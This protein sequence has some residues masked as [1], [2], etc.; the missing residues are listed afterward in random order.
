MEHEGRRLCTKAVLLF[1]KC[2]FYKMSVE[3]HISSKCLKFFLYALLCAAKIQQQYLIKRL[4]PLWWDEIE[5][6]LLMFNPLC[7]LQVSAR[8]SGT[9]LQSGRRFFFVLSSLTVCFLPVVHRCALSRW[10]LSA[11]PSVHA[12]FNPRYDCWTSALTPQRRLEPS[13][14]RAT[15]SLFPSPPLCGLPGKAF[16][17]C[18]SKICILTTSKSLFIG[19]RWVQTQRNR[20][21]LQPR[22]YYCSLI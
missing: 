9:F 15:R 20:D 17:S 18:I 14:Y 21:N 5:S 4:I 13:R 11:A 6:W 1:L 12:A 19:K 2:I 22:A 16:S 3:L 7:S 10:S 8:G